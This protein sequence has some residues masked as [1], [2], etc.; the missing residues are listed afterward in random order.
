MQSMILNVCYPQQLDSS[1]NLPFDLAV[2]V[3]RQRGVVGLDSSGSQALPGMKQV[4]ELKENLRW[5]I[6]SSRSLRRTS[7]SLST[8]TRGESKDGFS[9]WRS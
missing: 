4:L 1:Y 8:S 3:V 2:D 5:S 9:S 7:S 6:P